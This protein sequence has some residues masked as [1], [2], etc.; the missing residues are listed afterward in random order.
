MDRDLISVFKTAFLNEVDGQKFYEMAAECINTPEVKEALLRLADEEKLHQDYLKSELNR[1]HGQSTW[2]M[3][4]SEIKL[5]EPD[6]FKTDNLDFSSLDTALMVFSVG[7]RL[8][9]EAE[10]YY[11]SNKE[12]LGGDLRLQILFD[13]LAQWEALHYEYFKRLYDQY[14]GERVV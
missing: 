13:K 10:N 6:I 14:G 7:M 3:D 2:D 5:P 12:F 8:E 9:K 4:K 1:L 11:R